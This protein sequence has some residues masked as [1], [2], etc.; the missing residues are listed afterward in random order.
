ML[1][2]VSS[3]NYRR[4]RWWNV[5]AAQERIATGTVALDVNGTGKTSQR[6]TP[7]V[8]YSGRCATSRVTIDDLQPKNKN[9][10]A[11]FRVYSLDSNEPPCK[12]RRRIVLGNDRPKSEKQTIIQTLVFDFFV[13]NKQT[14]K[15]KYLWHSRHLRAARFRSTIRLFV[16]LIDSTN[17]EFMRRTNQERA[18]CSLISQ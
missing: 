14:N 3:S 4:L 2:S 9:K 10:S 11:G 13:K 16:P 12:C 7:G 1:L 6:M 15:Q 17:H 5:V 18:V 8:I